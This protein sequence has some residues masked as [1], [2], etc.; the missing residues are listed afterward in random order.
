MT[1]GQ[2]MRYL[3]AAEGHLR[4][5]DRP[6]TQ[7]EVVAAIRREQKK[8]VSQSYLSQI[9]N[10][11]RPHLSANTRALFAKFFRVHP[12]FLVDDPKGFDAK[13]DSDL[14]TTEGKLD[15]WFVHLAERFQDD[16][17]V[18]DA[19]MRI[20]GQKNTRK[21]ILLLADILKTP[22]LAHRVEAMVSRRAQGTGGNSHE[23]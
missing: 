6:M 2:K 19:L 12:G 8:R 4:G 20:A 22:G 11:L 1:L 10:G 9:E 15:V 18:S 7:V 14:G 17:K 5:L 21:A 13:L 3:R 16:S 23:L